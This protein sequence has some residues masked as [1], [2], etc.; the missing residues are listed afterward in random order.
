MDGWIGLVVVQSLI[1]IMGGWGG[2]V[3]DIENRDGHGVMVEKE[4]NGRPH[5]GL[6]VGLSLG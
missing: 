6:W 1:T 3:L 5:I 4:K 2:W